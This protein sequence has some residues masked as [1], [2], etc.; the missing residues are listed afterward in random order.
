MTILDH[1]FYK[2]RTITV[3]RQLLGAMLVR[4][5]NGTILSGIITE[6]EAYLGRDDSA[7]H[8]YRRRTPRNSV[9]FGPPG[10]AYVYLVYG[11]HHMLNI[12]TEK[13]GRPCAVLIRAFKPI[14]GLRHMERLRGRK[15]RDLSNGPGKLCQAMAI[16]KS[17]NGWDVKPGKSLWIESHQ[18]FLDAAIHAGPR[19]GIDYAHPEDRDAPLRFWLEES[20]LIRPES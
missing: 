2:R 8:A 6:T 15:G 14:D 7:C 17:L 16:D 11:I 19:I 3:A 12:V 4:D 13:I 5:L 10:F 18:G 20:N 1:G 9:M